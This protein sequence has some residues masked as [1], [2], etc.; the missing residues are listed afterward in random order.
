MTASRWI[1]DQVT[2]FYRSLTTHDTL[3]DE[4][5]R[6][7][8]E[9]TGVLTQEIQGLYPT[10]TEIYDTITQL[11]GTIAEQAGVMHA[12]QAT[13]AAQTLRL[14]ALANDDDP[15]TALLGATPEADP[16]EAVDL[17]VVFAVE[18]RQN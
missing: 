18:R 12:L 16:A 13:V 5:V 2:Q 11:H 6:S 9:Y 14:R 1:P 4:D 15:D 3:T 10:V 7:L 8:L 17:T